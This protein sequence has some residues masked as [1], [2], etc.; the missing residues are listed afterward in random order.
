MSIF[1]HLIQ[2]LILAFGCLWADDENM[3]NI[4]KQDCFVAVCIL[5]I[6]F[7]NFGTEF[8]CLRADNALN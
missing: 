4:M 2:G 1:G 7:S 8:G 6:Q 3:K 5:D